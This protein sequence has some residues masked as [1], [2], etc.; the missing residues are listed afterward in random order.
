MAL[1]N[2][3]PVTRLEAILDGADITPVTRLEYFL[4]QAATND[5]ELPAVTA[6]DNGDVLGVVNGAWA[7]T[8]VPSGV[9]IINADPNGTATYDSGK[10]AAVIPCDISLADFLS[11][12][13]MDAA[14]NIYGFKVP[15]F[16]NF[17]MVTTLEPPDWTYEESNMVLLPYMSA[18]DGMTKL[19]EDESMEYY[20]L[21]NN[22]P[23][24]VQFIVTSLK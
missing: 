10:S 15:V 19:S 3:D 14:N 6:A 18:G 9:L 21:I 7:K 1:E 20:F 5:D 4:K 2:L 8:E 22:N 23:A 16:L 11:I 17:P 24:T 13:C 12:A